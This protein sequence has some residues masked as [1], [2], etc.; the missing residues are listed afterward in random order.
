MPDND[1]KPVFILTGGTGSGKTTFLLQMI[2]IL[3][4][5]GLS[6]T[7]FAAASVAEDGPSG[8]YDILDLVSGRKLSLATRRFTEGWEQSGNFF[9]N[10]EGIRMGRSI[11]EDT[12]MQGIDLMVVDEIGP[13]ELEGKIWADSL[14][15]ILARRSCSMLLVVREKLLGLVIKHWSLDDAVI[16]DIRQ[17]KP[18]EAAAELMSITGIQ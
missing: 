8:S 11:L 1:H 6:I 2:G 13:F 5:Y 10:P 12:Q 17:N 3:R 9:F 4:G 16:I 7:G 18:D 15:R 14:S